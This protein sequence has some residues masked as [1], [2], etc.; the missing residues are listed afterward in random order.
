[1]SGGTVLD[2]TPEPLTATNLVGPWLLALGRPGFVEAQLSNTTTPEAVVVL[3]ASNMKL[4]GG[5]Q[6]WGEETL[7]GAEAVAGDV[8]FAGP[9]WVRLRVVSI[10]GVNA[11]VNGT[12]AWS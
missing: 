1:M 12:I 10:S 9:V 6:I 7:T 3:E 4:S 2:L 11:A 5:K 8:V